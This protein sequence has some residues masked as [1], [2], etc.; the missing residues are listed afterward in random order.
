MEKTNADS[1]ALELKYADSRKA[2]I[3]ESGRAMV[4]D[5]KEDG[6]V[7]FIE[8]REG[9]KLIVDM[10]G[11]P[12]TNNQARLYPYKVDA[13]KRKILLEY[14][15]E[16]KKFEENARKVNL[17]KIAGNLLENANIPTQGGNPPQ[18]FNMELFY[19]KLVMS[20]GNETE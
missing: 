10:K 2:D 12:L 14:M 7:A 8:E 4:W 5:L 11:N 19:D 1:E 3:D 20:D 17:V 13:E 6:I 18:L 16:G 15:E 9:K